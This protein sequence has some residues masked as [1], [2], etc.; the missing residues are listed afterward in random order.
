MKEFFKYFFAAL[1][2]MFVYGFASVGIYIVMMIMMFSMGG[3]GMS[4]TT[5]VEDNTVL[6]L[7]LNGTI[8]DRSVTQDDMYGMLTMSLKIEQTTGLTDILRCIKSAKTDKKI[9]AIYLEFSTISTDFAN[10]QNIRA[11]LEDFAESGKPIYAWAESY[12]LATYYLASTATKIY[13]RELGGL[14]LKGIASQSMFYKPLLDR[15]GIDM[16]VIR[17][18]KFKSAVEP[19]LQGS[20]S[21]ANRMQMST[22]VNDIWAEVSKDICKSKN[23]DAADFENHIDNLDYYSDLDL[24]VNSGMIDA[25]ISHKEAEDSIKAAIEVSYDEGLNIVSLTGYLS[26]L[27]DEKPKNDKIAIIYAEGEIDPSGNENSNILAD[28]ICESF[29]IAQNDDDIK[30]V[31]FRINSPGG[32]ATESE[33]IYKAAKAFGEKKPLVVSMG[34]YAAS[35]G[36]YI[37]CPAQKIVA[38][39]STITGSIGVF[40]VIPNVEKLLKDIDLNVETVGTHKH[41]GMGSMYTKMD[42][43]EIDVIQQSVETVY[44]RFISHVAEGRN[45]TTAEVDSIGQGRVWSGAS[46]L[47]IGL[48]D[49]L[50]SLNDALTIA[51][52]LADISD[53]STT[54][55]PELGDDSMSMLLNLLSMKIFTPESQIP[56]ELAPVLHEYER[57]KHLKGVQCRMEPFVIEY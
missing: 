28:K 16:Q 35:G 54:A 11:A 44:G 26:S 55:L 7:R 47:K 8:T 52:E 12:D 23:I 39:P 25:L 49:T 33:E 45:M 40:G 5:K 42:S 22:L 29:R 21:D 50:G 27:K 38:M 10:L 56:E 31:V 15:L 18:G 30:A 19:Y 20:M 43:R 4:S 36:Y 17:H 41:S 14:E 48:V 13:M 2:A 51:A 9:S 24:C 37:A 1:A 34:S 6:R 53:Y 57:I 32:S 46:A 3:S